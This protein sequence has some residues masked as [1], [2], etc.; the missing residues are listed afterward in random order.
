MPKNVFVATA[1]PQTLLGKVTALLQ[2]PKVGAYSAVKIQSGDYFPSREPHSHSSVQFWI[3][4]GK[5]LRDCVLS[6]KL[7]AMITICT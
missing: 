2:T 4:L 7:S 6:D 1:L 5:T 3:L